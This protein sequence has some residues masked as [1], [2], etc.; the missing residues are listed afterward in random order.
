MRFAL[1]LVLPLATAA[2]EQVKAPSASQSATLATPA[3]NATRLAK[4]VF[5]DQ[6]TAC[7]CTQKRIDETWAALQVALGPSAST[8]V[9]RIHVDTQAKQA[10][11]YTLLRPLMVTPGVYFVDEGNAVIELL[12]GE[13]KQEQITAVLARK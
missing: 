4:I 6:E 2:C 1:L 7:D 11:T 12:Q 9:E 3:A 10:E 13:V 8:P 5:I